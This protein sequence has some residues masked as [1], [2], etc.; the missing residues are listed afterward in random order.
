MPNIP[1][2]L[3]YDGRPA[4]WTLQAGTPLSRVHEVAWGPCDFNPALADTHWGG[5][6]FDA[7]PDDQYG[8]I[9]AGSDDSVAISEALLRDLP[10][11]VHGARL[12]PRR[13]LQDRR[14]GWLR[15]RVALDLVSLRSAED[16]GA[17]GQDTWLTQAP[18]SEYG[19]TRRWG[20]AIRGWAPWATG[21]VWYSRREPDG[22]AYVFFADRCP[23]DPFEEITTGTPIP[24]AD[25]RL[26]GGAGYIYVR[27]FL[28]NYNVSL[29]P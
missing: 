7:T 13:Q 6:R 25:S 10:I 1:P 18:S 22:L 16:L 3:D 23:P 15:C 29:F 26:D 2:P 14:L 12:L 9:Y 24:V 5:G 21:F 11:D 27:G 8:Y 28:Q 4:R 17:V 19:F 20:Q